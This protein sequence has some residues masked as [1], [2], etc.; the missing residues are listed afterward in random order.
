MARKEMNPE[1]IRLVKELLAEYQPKDV[2]ELQDVLKDIFGPLM[3]DM[4]LGELDAELGYEKHDQ[5]PKETGNRRNGSYPKTV[6]SKMGELTLNIPRDRDGEYEPV[7]VPKGSRDISGIEEKVMSMYAKGMSDRD[8]SA[9]VEDIYGFNVS[10]ETISRIIDRI[11]PRLNEWQSRTLASCYPFLYVDAL[12]VPI[13]NDGRSTNKAVYSILGIDQNG[14]KDCLGFWI[15]ENEGAHFWLSIFDELRSRGV[16]KVGFVSIDGLSGLEEGIRS[17]FPEAIVQR[18]IVHLVRNSI[19][20]I[21]SKHYKAFCSDLKAMY[22]AVNLTTA[23]AALEAFKEKWSSYPSAIKVWTSN[24][25]HVEQLYD[26]P[27][28][29]RKIIYTTNTIESFNSALRKVTNRKSAFPND[30]SVFKILFLRT[31]DIAKKWTKPHSGWAVIRGQLDILFPDWD[32][33]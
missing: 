24:F 3:E 1:R 26:Y 28:E 32:S 7:I 20:Y 22:G 15:S 11:Q 17:I 31:M 9:T 14:M 25:N 18:C 12:V 4:L 2:L 33:L 10:H 19:K 6:R 8:I 30:N 13:K 29:I 5:S 27:A 23:Q 21:P 16:E